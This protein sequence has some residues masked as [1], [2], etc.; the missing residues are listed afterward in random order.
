MKELLLQRLGWIGLTALALGLLTY[1]LDRVGLEPV[2]L[3]EAGLL[4]MTPL[5][6]AAVG[7]CVN[8]K[9]GVVNIGLE[10]TL[11]ISAVAGVWVAEQFGSG[12]AGLIGGMTVGGLI[13]LVLGL[14]AVYGRSDQIIAGIGLNLFALGFTPYLLMSLWAFPGIHIFPRELM[15][16][17]WITPIGQIS[18]VTVLA[19]LLAILAH[20]LLHHT[21]LGF[22]IRAVG[23]K[24]EAVDVAGVRVDR[25]RLFTSVLGGAL[26]GLGGAFMPLA[27][28]G[29]V[30]KEIS[31]GRGFIALACVVF[32]GLEP[33]LALAA[34]FL[35]G[36]T[37]GIAYAVAVTPGVKER[38]P[39]YFVNMLPYVTTLLVVALVI[40][41]RRFPRTIGRP[42]ARE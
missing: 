40:G 27:W 3:L 11:L 16:P 37:E 8:E 31:A 19:V 33:L 7:E 22:R 29:G 41:R 2:S 30:V 38:I 17:R 32:A 10:G 34:A 36:L 5:A 24:P 25:L 9:A 14:L 1:G 4:A 23:E 21:V 42:Y 20:V 28:F 15:V 6:L 13:G 35:F 39:F 12:V 18:P 26:C